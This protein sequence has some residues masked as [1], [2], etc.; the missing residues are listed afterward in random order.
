M[1]IAHFKAYEIMH[2]NGTLRFENN[3]KYNYKLCFNPQSH[4]LI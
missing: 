2:L 4:K 3:N 1:M